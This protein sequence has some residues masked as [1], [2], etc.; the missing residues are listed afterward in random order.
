MQAQKSIETGTLNTS[1]AKNRLLPRLAFEGGVG[2]SGLG[3][4][5]GDTLDRTASTDFYN[6][7]AG[8]VLSY[9]LGNRSAHSQYNRRILEANQAK[10]SLQRIRQQVIIDTKEAVRRVQTDFKRIRTTRTARQ[11]AEKQLKAEQER[12]QLGLSTTRAV[13]EFQGDL[14]VGRGNEQRAIVDY[15]Q[16]LANLRRMTA[17]ALEDYQIVLQ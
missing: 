14:A 6:M 5:A 2:L 3:K 4:G 15:N 12:L 16:S 7:G 13:L 9:P 8:L 1:L 11:L 17:T 10:A